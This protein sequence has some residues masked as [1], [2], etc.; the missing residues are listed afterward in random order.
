MCSCRR[1][2]AVSEAVHRLRKSRKLSELS[3]K[4]IEIHHH[5]SVGDDNHHAAVSELYSGQHR[6]AGS[7][8]VEGVL[9]HDRRRDR[10]AAKTWATR[11]SGSC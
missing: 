11:W 8:E 5:E 7:D 1:P 9:R 6:P 10:R 3:E 4:L 2:I